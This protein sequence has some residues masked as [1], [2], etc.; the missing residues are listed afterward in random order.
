MLSPMFL[1]IDIGN[2]NVTLGLFDG[3]ALVTTWRLATEVSRTADEYAM[4]VRSLAE[5][6]GYTLEDIRSAAICS[7][8]PPLVATFNELCKDYLDVVPLVVGSG[9]KS[10]IRIL[11][12]DPRQVGPD[13]VVD[14]VA[15]NLLYGGPVI[16]VDFGTATVFDA[17]SAE[18]DYLGGAIA[19]GLGI[20]TE[21]LY[22]RASLLSR[23]ELVA[24]PKAIGRNT[25]NSMQSG[26]V[27]G[28]VGLIEGLIRRFHEELGTRAQ[29]VA[30]GGLAPVIASQT[31]MVDV[32]N[33]DLTL[34][35]LRHIYEINRKP[36]AA[37]PGKAAP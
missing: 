9:V 10:G 11:Y 15:A 30:T 20:S 8:V 14:A 17:V 36:D 13:R 33:V 28:Y 37:R 32:I 4:T 21:A 6:H 16:V 29:V 5:H 3:A 26:I 27:F 19:P 35:G 34:L 18:G 24:P 23:I 22:Q 25:M 7:S 1:A 31:P 2:T 12:D